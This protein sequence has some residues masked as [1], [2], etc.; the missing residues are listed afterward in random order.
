MKSYLIASL[1][2]LTLYKRIFYS[3]VVIY[4][5]RKMVAAGDD[6]V[7]IVRRFLIEQPYKEPHQTLP[8]LNLVRLWTM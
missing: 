8:F 7:E 3:F 6:F 2:F 5:C 1:R 4:A